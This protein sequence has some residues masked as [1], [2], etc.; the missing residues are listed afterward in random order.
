M[1]NQATPEQQALERQVRPTGPTVP[2]SLRRVQ[3]PFPGFFADRQETQDR[4]MA[5][6]EKRV[7][8]E[9]QAT[10]VIATPEPARGVP[11]QEEVERGEA[12]PRPPPGGFGG[13]SF[14]ERIKLLGASIGNLI[15]P[16]VMVGNRVI[17]PVPF[18]PSIKTPEEVTQIVQAQ[19]NLRNQFIELGD[20]NGVVVWRD[21][22]SELASVIA[23]GSEGAPLTEE[24]FLKA[25]HIEDWNTIISDDDV[26]WAGRVFIRALQQRGAT[27]E[28]EITTERRQNVIEQVT[29]NRSASAYG[30]LVTSGADLL[31][32]L[33]GFNQPQFPAG[34]STP[35]DYRDLLLDLGF[36]DNEVDTELLTFTSGIQ[37]LIDQIGEEGVHRTFL[38]S[39]FSGM[40]NQRLEDEL[41]SRI[42]RNIT[43]APLTA[44]KLPID[45]FTS[46][47]VD[48][49]AGLEKKLNF[50]P[51]GIIQLLPGVEGSGLG[52]RGIF[53]TQKEIEDF[54]GLF[55]QAQVEGAGTWEALAFANVNYD[56]NAFK[57]FLLL[58]TFDPLTY[59]GIGLYAKVLRPLP[60]IGRPLAGIELGFMKGVDQLALAAKNGLY[61]L[62]PKTINQMVTYETKQSV[63]I[64]RAGLLSD[65]LAQGNLLKAVD[66]IPLDQAQATAQKAVAMARN[67]PGVQH[68]L[69][70]TGRLIRRRVPLA[71]DEINTLASRL[72]REPIGLDDIREGFKMA[73]VD[74]IVGNTV[75]LEG[76]ALNLDEATDKLMQSM[77]VLDTP[78]GNRRALVRNWLEE[79]ITGVDEAADTLIS[80]SRSTKDLFSRIGLHIDQTVRAERRSLHVQAN[81]NIGSLGGIW[82]LNEMPNKIIFANMLDRFNRGFARLHLLFAFYSPFNVLENGLKTAFAGL[83]PMFF[84]NQV[85]RALIKTNG[86]VGTPE[87]FFSASGFNLELGPIAQNVNMVKGRLPGLSMNTFNRRMRAR[88]GIWKSF[89]GGIDEIMIRSGGRIGLQQQANYTNLAMD[90]WMFRNHPETMNRSVE[91]ID[92]WK[93]AL[94]AAGYTQE[95]VLLVTKEAWERAVVNP[96][97]LLGM[98]NEFT[99]HKLGMKD[100]MKILGKYADV[101][102]TALNHLVQ[103]AQ[104]GRLFPNLTKLLTEDMP[105]VVRQEILYSPELARLRFNS[106][107]DDLADNPPV[108]LEGLRVRTQALSQL[109]VDTVNIVTAQTRQVQQYTRDILNLEVKGRIYEEMWDE[110]LTPFIRESQERTRGYIGEL[111][112]ALDDPTIALTSEQTVQFELMFDRQ[113][114]RTAV[115]EDAWIRHRELVRQEFSV[116]DTLRSDIRGRG[117]NPNIDHPEIR[118]WWEG[119]NTARENHWRIARESL[120]RT[121]SGILEATAAAENIRL[122]KVVSRLGEDLT[123]AD[124][125]G[126]Y[127]SVP[128]DLSRDLFIP[129]LGVLQEKALWVER[130]HARANS[131]A[132]QNGMA[133]DD[134]GYTR[135]SIGKVYDDIV[136][137]MLGSRE[138][139]DLAAPRLQQLESMREELLHYSTRKGVQNLESRKTILDDFSRDVR[140]QLEADPSTRV[141]FGDQPAQRA[142]LQPGE[143]REIGNR[144]IVITRLEDVA[145]DVSAL[146]REMVTAGIPEAEIPRLPL[147]TSL[148]VR[149][150]ND[151][152]V[153][154]L[155]RQ[156]DD[157]ATIDIT[158]KEIGGREVTTNIEE[159]APVARFNLSEL[160]ELGRLV[161]EL[162]PTART[163]GGTRLTGGHRKVLQEVNLEQ[164]RR[165]RTSTDWLAERQ[166]ALDAANDEMALD[167]PDYTHPTAVNAVG[168]AA[169]P[170]WTYETHRVFW[171]A[172]NWIKRPGTF[173]ALGR[174]QDATDQGYI[175]VPGTDYQ[176]NP[177]RGTIWMGGLKRLFNRDFPDY[178]DRFPEFSNALDQLGRYGFF[179][180]L[181]ISAGI[182]IFGAKSPRGRFS[183]VGELV[184]SI[185]Q[186]PLEAYVAAFPDSQAA[187]VILEIILP[188]RWRDYQVGLAAGA[189]GYD[190]D[191]IIDKRI[192]NTPLTEEEERQWSA[193]QR[194]F[195]VGGGIG[196]NLTNMQMSLLRL[197]PQEKVAFDAAVKEVIAECVG[198]PVAT[199]N[200]MRK[201]SARV[202]EFFPVPAECRDL[203]NELEGSQ[204]RGLSSHLRESEVGKNLATVDIF[205]AEVE[206]ESTIVLEGRESLNNQWRQGVINR[207]RWE[208]DTRELRGRVSQVIDDKKADPRFQ[209]EVDGA[210]SQVPVTLQERK[211]FAIAQGFDPIQRDPVEELLAEWFQIEVKDRF[212]IETGLFV[213]DWDGFFR[214]QRIIEDLVPEPYKSEFLD[215]VHA[216]DTDLDSQR[217][218]DYEGYIRPYQATFDIVLATFDEVE[219]AIINEANVTDDED[220]RRALMEMEDSNGRNIVSNF[221]AT[222]TDF[223]TNT[224]ILDPAMDARL[225][226]WEGLSPR[227]DRGLVLWR[228]LRTQYGFGAQPEDPDLTQ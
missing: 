151:D 34:V 21:L 136:E 91:I 105:E 71:L 154:V 137:G 195:A 127:Q 190:A 37:T 205:W 101:G 29:A 141:L 189:L 106:F 171:L 185:I 209:M 76:K 51:T 102:P 186:T 123:S 207:T 107:M 110:I 142:V 108:D 139:A 86:L 196:G 183:Q 66:Q 47:V 179:P 74:Q 222:L 25:A 36:T 95:E 120:A 19:E 56:T 39:E 87:A 158:A 199:Q 134:I 30:I 191:T 22:I 23:A 178:A 55:R 112:A 94:S 7:L 228:Q 18:Q 187:K 97:T 2:E 13:F 220:R 12:A 213:T 62:A 226:M 119:F 27:P 126:L 181:S 114:E 43:A 64:V 85:D 59:F 17:Q 216:G 133:A 84:G 67:N 100:T 165:G 54:D 5:A 211:D 89:W 135:T 168:R 98:S 203:M 172:R 73:E 83:D 140:N 93:P 58:T 79:I 129:E 167:F 111:R 225:T 159:L 150:P 11:S 148:D 143:S 202:S 176:V 61:N 180:N 41:N 217:R 208:K 131:I 49:L 152:L 214:K 42:V 3:E 4:A 200:L 72:G 20:E 132:A 90:R 78:G 118:A 57:R 188:S 138:I 210:M 177:L 103:E 88:T 38:R 164:F 169:A 219:Q 215:R 6:E 149:L 99:P 48:P 44:L 63:D 40:S 198:V 147:T 116:R 223:R 96:D 68:P 130:I 184:P 1:V 192:T 8:L 69:A 157:E 24:D 161:A 175:S 31:D 182:S 197:K 212:D 82:L 224:R 52:R 173:A 77:A 194:E 45:W 9:R 166:K 81:Q 15:T 28:V 221:R 33:I 170:F 153:E 26:R 160:R 122:P 128:G 65:Q 204:F 35:E 201:A 206:Q 113:L 156:T 146:T 117:E 121:D 16:P 46:R 174:Y 193:A 109:G 218:S 50:I 155:I 70:D 32:A 104:N 144:G 227:S 10:G 60:I 115:L 124:V 75:G 163:M 125:A 53:S 145:P 80:G 92:S 162:H 14:G